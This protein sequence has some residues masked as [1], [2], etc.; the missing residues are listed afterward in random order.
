MVR[1]GLG[2]QCAGLAARRLGVMPVVQI[3]VLFPLDVFFGYKVRSVWPP[4]PVDGQPVL[5]RVDMAVSRGGA[6]GVACGEV[7][8]GMGCL[9]TRHSRK[10]ASPDM[11]RSSPL[12]P[13]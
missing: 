3:M 7:V 10:G 6:S 11:L 2:V 12:F 8:R 13:T 1:G 9:A 5:P 4:L